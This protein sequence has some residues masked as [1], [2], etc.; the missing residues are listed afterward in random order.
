[1]AILKRSF[2]E[3]QARRLVIDFGEPKKPVIR[4]RQLGLPREPTSRRA[5]ARKRAF[6]RKAIE[7]KEVDLSSQMDY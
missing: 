3:L 7:K 1:V 5:R 6:M 4:L 2:F